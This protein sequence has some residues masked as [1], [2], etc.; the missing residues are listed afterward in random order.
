MLESDQWSLVCPKLP[1]C[2]EGLWDTACPFVH[3]PEFENWVE[4]LIAGFIC[5][6]TFGL[7]RSFAAG[8]TGC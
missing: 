2:R 6:G 5:G 1:S 7:L 8:V 3:K 4:N